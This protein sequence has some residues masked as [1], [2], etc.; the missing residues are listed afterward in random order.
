MKEQNLTKPLVKLILVQNQS[1]TLK[2]RT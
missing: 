2:V 1:D